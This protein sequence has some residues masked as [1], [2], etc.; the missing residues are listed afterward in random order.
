MGAGLNRAIRKGAGAL[1][2]ALYGYRETSEAQR[3]PA[4]ALD[5]F[6][7]KALSAGQSVHSTDS[8][9]NRAARGARTKRAAGLAHRITTDVDEP[10]IQALRRK[11]FLQ[12]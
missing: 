2:L 6:I 5:T 1:W 11:N 7:H 4:R 12:A 9:L 8:S 3:P 10:D